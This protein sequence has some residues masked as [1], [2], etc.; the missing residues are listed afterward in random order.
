MTETDLPK[1][2][3]AQKYFLAKNIGTKWLEQT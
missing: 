1:K 3:L 2:T